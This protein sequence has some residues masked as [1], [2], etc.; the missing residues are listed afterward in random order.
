[1]NVRNSRSHS[2]YAVTHRS[3]VCLSNVA[4][5]L[6]FVRPT[7]PVEIFGNVSTP[8]FGTLA[9][10]WHPRKIL[11]RSSK[12]NPPSGFLPINE[13]YILEILQHRR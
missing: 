12:G 5:C 11:R 6:T 9:F 1:V 7:Q 8:H 13:G 4:V 3:V 10:S 2:L